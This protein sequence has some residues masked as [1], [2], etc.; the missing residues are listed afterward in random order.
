MTENVSTNVFL[1]GKIKLNEADKIKPI[2][3][4]YENPYHKT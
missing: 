4:E 2:K 1:R 3:V